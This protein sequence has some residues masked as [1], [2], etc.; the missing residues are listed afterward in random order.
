MKFKKISEYLPI[1]KAYPISM[2][3]LSKRLGTSERGTRAIILAERRRGVPICSDCKRGGGY[4]LPADE[5]EIFR[6]IRQQK[7]RIRTAQTALS[8]VLK[9]IAKS[10]GGDKNV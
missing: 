9:Y 1:G 8:G 5:D 10:K 2:K 7:A 3:T 6:Y 4:Y